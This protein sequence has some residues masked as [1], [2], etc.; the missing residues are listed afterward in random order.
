MET[1]LG[2]AASIIFKAHSL[3]TLKDTFVILPSRRATFFFR[4]ELSKLSTL[5]FISPAILSIDDFI[6]QNSD[7]ELIGNTELYFEMFAI[8][9]ELDPKLTFDK[10]LSWAPI[11]VKDFESIDLA[12]IENPHLLFRYM[13]ETEAI[14]RWNLEENH[15]FSNSTHKYFSFFEQVSEVYE[16]LKLNLKQKKMGYK[17][18]AYRKAAENINQY[19]SKH[20]SKN[21]YYFVGLNALSK[22]EEHIVQQL[23]SAKVGH[24][25][26]DTDQYYMVNE[27]KAGKK[28]RDYKFSR[29]YGQWG[30]EGQSLKK[31]IK[32]INIFG[33]QND[34]QQTDLVASIVQKTPEANHVLVV[35]NENQFKPLMGKVPLVTENFNITM[36]MPINNS[37]FFGVVSLYFKIHLKPNLD[38]SHFVKIHN[39]QFSRILDHPQLYQC[40]AAE[41]GQ[42]KINEIK[43]EIIKQNKVYIDLK[44]IEKQKARSRLLEV[45]FENV[46]DSPELAA[47]KLHALIAFVLKIQNTISSPLEIAFLNN[48][49][50]QL[51][52]LLTLLP[53][54]N[55]IS[56]SSFHILLIEI[57]KTQKV[58]F[59]GNPTAPLQIMSML[60]TRCL[61][62]ENVTFLSLNE[63]NLPSAEK[64]KSFIPLDAAIIFDL[65]IYSDNDAI[66]AYHFFRLLQKAQNINFLYLTSGAQS[67]GTTEK[68]RFITQI[69][70]ELAVYNPNIRL[71]Y[72]QLHFQGEVL[73][74][75]ETIEI[76]KTEAIIS[77]IKH[78]LEEKGLFPTSINDYL[79]C[80]LKFYWARIEKL[81]QEDEIKEQ[82][83]AD[84]FGNIVHKVLEI[85]DID[86][87]KTNQ[88]VDVQ[89]IRKIIKNLE[90]VLNQVIQQYFLGFDTS[91]GMNA[92]FKQIAL[93]ILQDFFQNQITTNQFPF[94]VIAT[95]KKFQTI[96]T[97][98]V[99]EQALKVKISGV[100][101][102]IELFENQLYIVDYKTGKVEKRELSLSNEGIV[103][104]LRNSNK[105]KFRQLVI[106]KYLII[107]NR[108]EASL[109][110]FIESENIEILPRI[111]SFRNLQADL[112]L[113]CGT[114]SDDVL[115]TEIE[116]L[117]KH[118][119]TDLLSI[120]LAFSQT[121]DTKVCA[122]CD[123]NRIC[124]RF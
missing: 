37:L 108:S 78:F 58:P 74:S 71:H 96:F 104:D 91:F 45:F 48:F 49:G 23:V 21:T 28:L 70:E 122:F 8:F 36:G 52:L 25:I 15:D 31:T 117:F 116:A 9:S 27:N 106:Y 44:W 13:S 12:L 123:F 87:V 75:H 118:I 102:R 67:I 10:F 68:S 73:Q 93:K 120:E 18:M 66:M 65:P 4:Q 54:R 97:P 1:F 84:V 42:S 56:L 86:F 83:G 59:S 81:N 98:L 51:T 89:A 82:I 19:I 38:G 69:E 107:K 41:I 121:H 124:K 72:P 94:S 43:E 7:L 14:K 5:P 77:K 62:F 100:V 55:D 50:N 46:N 29:K 34:A 40:L 109:F 111:Y 105:K 3:K 63:G 112:S 20:E 2:H 17:G 90:L 6:I 110:K 95:E 114:L 24:C 64:N 103:D 22:A 57:L 85:I 119:V 88:N 30:T 35:L 113:D 26:W 33:L 76:P 115:I 47:Q 39:L 79:D 99:N 92:I 101:D 53:K 61:D 60:E 16:R 11:L 32:N 80:S